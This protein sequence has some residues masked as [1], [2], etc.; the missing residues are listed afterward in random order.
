MLPF[1]AENDCCL[2]LT[3]HCLLNTFHCLFT[4]C[5]LPSSQDPHDSTKKP[6]MLHIQIFPDGD[7]GWDP[8]ASTWGGVASQ[9]T[10]LACCAD[11]KGFCG[12][13][14]SAMVRKI[15]LSDSGS[16]NHANIVVDESI[17]PMTLLNIMYSKADTPL[18]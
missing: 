14:A 7:S 4:V 13:S 15:F 11:T 5:S 8:S 16:G 9:L 10:V 17:P 12:S 2:S 6:S 18:R 3:C 1:V